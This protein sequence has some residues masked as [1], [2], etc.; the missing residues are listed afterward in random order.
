MWQKAYNWAPGKLSFL[1]PCWKWRRRVGNRWWPSW[2]FTFTRIFGD[3]ENL[4]CEVQNLQNRSG[5]CALTESIK[6]PMNF[7]IVVKWTEVFRLQTYIQLERVE[8]VSFHINYRFHTTDWSKSNFSILASKQYVVISNILKHYAKSVYFQLTW[9]FF[10][11]ETET[12]SSSESP[13]SPKSGLLVEG[14]F[15]LTKN[16]NF[17]L[18]LEE[19]YP[20]L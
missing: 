13:T 4:M 9:H 12:S 10:L 16:E 19:P 3:L 14:C 5:S 20:L 7:S 17:E 8:Y 15:V 11:L 2:G 6:I 1:W 18:F